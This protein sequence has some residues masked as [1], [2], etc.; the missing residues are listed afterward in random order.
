MKNSESKKQVDLISLIKKK[1]LLEKVGKGTYRVNPCP[2]C[3]HYDHFTIFAETNSYFSFSG[4]CKGGSA[5][6]Y[7]LEVE[8]KSHDDAFHEY[9]KLLEVEKEKPP[10]QPPVVKEGNDMDYTEWICSLYQ[11]TTEKGKQYFINRGI[12]N[13]LIEKYKLSIGQIDNRKCMVLPVWEK[14]IVVYYSARFLDEKKPKYKNATGTAQ[15][16]NIDYLKA[17]EKSTVL[18]TE[19]IFDALSLEAMGYKA[20][21]LGGTQHADKLKEKI[22]QAACDTIFLTAFDN[23]KA[24]QECKGQFP[25]K[26]IEIPEQFKDINQWI[27]N[28]LQNVHEAQNSVLEIKSSID[29]QLET[30]GQA[31]T[32][33]AYLDSGFHSDIQEFLS[34]KDKRTGFENLD[35]NMKGLYPGLYV[36]GGISSVGKTTFTHQLCDQ[37]AE[38][39]GHVI[40]FS[41]EQSRLEMVSKSIARTTAKINLDDAVSSVF[42][43]SGGSSI[44]V[45]DAIKKYR[46]TAENVNIIEGNFNTDVKTIREYVDAYRKANKENPVVVVDYLQI[47]PA[48]DERMSDKQRIDTNVT[49]LKRMSRDFSLTVFVISSLNRGNYLSPIDFESFKESGGIE[50]TA[51]VVWGLQLEAINDPVFYKEKSVN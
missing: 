13:G 24:G 28:S 47:M 2:V 17:S 4:C 25:Y 19:G 31:D 30:A 49:E 5:F 48:I 32:V 42:I 16:F 14:G 43:R 6:D 29:A 41:L 37:I 8:E 35:L 44:I 18:I 34:Y 1:H 7:L 3:G 15:I 10:S 50:Y 27:V 36:I 20:I 22:K 23:D 11:N 39:G 9:Q 45:K 40:Y 46:K 21:A 38:Q 26:A 12:P 33:S 51:D